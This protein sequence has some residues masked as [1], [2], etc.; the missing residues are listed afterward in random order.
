MKPE[1][2][3]LLRLCFAIAAFLNGVDLVVEAAD[4]SSPAPTSVVEQQAQP[5]SA[6]PA[7]DQD[8]IQERGLLP[9]VTAPIVPQG[10]VVSPGDRYRAPTP[11]L[12]SVANA[13]RITFRSVSV[14]LR[15]PPNLPVTV[16]VEI[17]VGYFSSAHTQRLTQPYVQGTGTL[18]RYNDQEGD[19][20][21][22]PIRLDITLRELPNGQSFTFSPQFTL[23]P[24]YDV[25]TSS[26]TFRLEH[27]CDLVGKSEIDLQWRSP[28]DQFHSVSFSLRALESRLFTDF[29]WSG[30]QLS[31]NANVHEVPIR[32]FEKDPHVPGGVYRPPLDPTGTPLLPGQT[33]Q[34]D[35]LLTQGNVGPYHQTTNVDLNK[36]QARL[37]YDI[38]RTLLTFPNF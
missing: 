35:Y 15:V 7:P 27:D 10:G 3:Y 20:K 30:N 11:S 9:G 6:S 32:F 18:I 28:D 14:N 4:V 16:P 38:T 29:V 1:P 33:Q 19:G 25:H 17:S 24:L 12:T 34:F 21:P 8:A 37:K 5:P 22:R 31:A 26:L 2:D 36:C 23:T 13:I